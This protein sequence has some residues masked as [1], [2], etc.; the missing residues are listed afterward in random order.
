MEYRKSNDAALI[1]DNRMH[2]QVSQVNQ[3]NVPH[4]GLAFTRAKSEYSSNMVDL[5]ETVLLKR[6]YERFDV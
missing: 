3:H 4:N 2:F 6:P 1:P 5:L